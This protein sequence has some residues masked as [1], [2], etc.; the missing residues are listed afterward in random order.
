MPTYGQTRMKLQNIEPISYTQLI[1][2]VQ[3]DLHE[4][5]RGKLRQRCYC[6]IVWKYHLEI[7]KRA[8]PNHFFPSLHI[9][10]S[11]QQ[12]QMFTS[13]ASSSISW[14]KILRITATLTSKYSYSKMGDTSHSLPKKPINL[15]RGWRTHFQTFHFTPIL[16]LLHFSISVYSIKG[17]ERDLNS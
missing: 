10:H 9:P 6:H 17:K 8:L 3:S 4:I 5:Q 16:Y 15:L 14:Q 11:F 1:V 12:P 7:L 2:N 13:K